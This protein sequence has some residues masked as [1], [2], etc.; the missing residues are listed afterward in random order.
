MTDPSNDLLTP[1]DFAKTYRRRVYRGLAIM[2]GL[3]LVHLGLAFII[4][5]P[6]FAHIGLDQLAISLIVGYPL[7]AL[8]YGAILL[9]AYRDYEGVFKG[10]L[11][12]TFVTSLLSCGCWVYALNRIN[13]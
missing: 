9:V 7:I 1:E 8:F 4:S 11:I 2:W 3:N 5:R 10:L 12:A 13:L 6:A